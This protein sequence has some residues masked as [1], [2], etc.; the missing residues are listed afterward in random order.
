MAGRKKSSTPAA[1]TKKV[2]SKDSL[3]SIGG[4]AD[5][6]RL[7]ESYT[8]LVLGIVVVI[9]ASI[10]LVSFLRGK[11][12][13]MNDTEKGASSTQTSITQEMG[14]KQGD[15]TVKAGDDLWSIAE[16]EYNDGFRWKEIAEANNI[17]NASLIE[18]G[19]SLVIPGKEE[20]N[21]EAIAAVSV[22]PAPSELTSPDSTPTQNKIS[23]NSYTVKTGDDLW[24]IA[25]AAYGDGYQWVK[26]AQANNLVTPDVIHAGNVLSLPR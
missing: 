19:E 16:R 20:K 11:G 17:E 2:E 23:G 21:E 4:L 13:E 26:I 8:S 5:Y 12:L 14:N 25:V 15:Y 7:G 24:D 3:S 18:E 1:Q 9:I 6:F 22:T 10:L